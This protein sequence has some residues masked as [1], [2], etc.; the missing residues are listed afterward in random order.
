MPSATVLG[1]QQLGLVPMGQNGRFFER[2]QF[3]FST[4]ALTSTIQTKMRRVENVIPVMDGIPALAVKQVP[5]GFLGTVSASAL[6]NLRVPEAGIITAAGFLVTT[7]VA[8]DAANIWTAGIINKGAAGSGTAVV[9]NIATAANSNNSTGGAAFTANV[10]RALTLTG[11]AADLVVA[12]GDVLQ[13]TLTKASS[14]ADLVNLY[15]FVV[16]S[17]S[18]TDEVLYWA[19]TQDSTGKFTVP[20]TNLLT[21]GR[22]GSNPTSALKG[23]ALVIGY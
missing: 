12:A 9:V 4:T 6:A 22:T 15:P 17:T 10:V 16:M 19:D 1:D 8:T 18:G 14:A 7:T 21:I 3:A 2:T 23:N 20:S 11:T 5:F 13:L